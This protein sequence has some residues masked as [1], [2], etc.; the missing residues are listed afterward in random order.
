MTT[1]TSAEQLILEMINRARMD[2]DGEAARLAQTH[3]GFTLNEGLAAGTISST[4]KQV[5][6][7]NNTL[8]GVADNHNAAMLSSHVLDN[9]SLNPHTQ[10]G[11]GSEVT[12]IANAGYQETYPAFQTYHDENIAWQGTSGA[13]DLASMTQQVAALMGRSSSWPLPTMCAPSRPSSSA[14]RTVCVA[15]LADDLRDAAACRSAD[16]AAMPV[17][18]STASATIAARPQSM[19]SGADGS[20]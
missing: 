17:A 12:R 3:P 13:I 6:A 5:L 20:R 7:G 15:T 2:P 10:A 14:A 8:A 4:P 19:Y 9:N 16:R 18:T 11:D 1:M